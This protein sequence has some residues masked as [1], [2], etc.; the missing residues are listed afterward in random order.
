MGR[1]SDLLADL[2]Y[3]AR[4]STLLVA[5]VAFYLAIE[6]I[7]NLVSGGP[8]FLVSALIFAAFVVPAMCVYL[9]DVLDARARG[10][11]P[12]PPSIEHLQWF[13]SA[14]SLLQLLYFLALVYAAYLLG[15]LFGAVVFVAVLLSFAVVVPASLAILAL[16]HSPL[17]SVNPWAIGRL[18]GRCGATYWVAPAYALTAIAAIG[19]LSSSRVPDWLTEMVAL[20][21]LFAF[22]TLV[23]GIVRPHRL[24]EQVDI[25]RPVEPG[26]EQLEARLT[27]ERTAVLN[28]AY[29]LVSRGNR[30]GGLGH[31]FDWIDR[32]PDPDGAWRW[33]FEQ[34]LRWEVTD[35][36]LLFGQQYLGR[37]LGSGDQVAAVKLIAR[38]RLENEAFRPLPDDREPARQAAEQCGN[39]DLARTL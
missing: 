9:V 23:G 33:F 32:D 13:N 7:S 3:P 35:A 12:G 14:W 34:M 26:A 5:F 27:N 20:F 18:I 28:H 25:H 19:A 17:E 31:V 8:L 30:E 24:H 10:A 36:A 6:L 11:A 21:L 4:N 29:G 2:V 38:C 39:A 15:S 1:A 22:Y 16:T 37:L